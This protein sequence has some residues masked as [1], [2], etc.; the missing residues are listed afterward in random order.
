MFFKKKENK[1]QRT[2]KEA[3]AAPTVQPQTDS[4]PNRSTQSHPKKG[5]PLFGKVCCTLISLS[6]IA[7]SCYSIVTLIRNSQKGGESKDSYITL[8]NRNVNQTREA[9][10][11]FKQD[12]QK[13]LK[14]YYFIGTK[15]YVSENKITPS[16]YEDNLFSRAGGK[17]IALLD[18]TNKVSYNTSNATLIKQNRPYIDLDNTP[19]GDYLLYPYSGEDHLRKSDIAP[20]SLDLAKGVEESV[21]SLP[22]GDKKTRKTITLKNN[23]NSPYTIISV[24]ESGSHLPA[25]TYDYVIRNQQYIKG[26]DG[27]YSLNTNRNSSPASKDQ[28]N[29][30]AEKRKDEKGYKCKVAS[31]L[32]EAVKTKAKKLIVFTSS[33]TY[34]SIFLS[35]KSENTL[36]L[37]DTDLKGYDEIPEIREAT[38][39]IEHAGENYYK[40]P[41][42]S[43][44]PLS[45]YK[46]RDVTR[47]PSSSITD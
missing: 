32:S 18:I 46:G 14:D 22:S 41:F 31:S 24:E 10:N 44:S 19:E 26:E 3:K 20:Y 23:L 36:V 6:R 30:Y 4:A 13:K 29:S 2:E 37:T 16:R 33:S 17:D 34:Q 21:Y 15:L 47:I 25:D 43:F 38:G 45:D 12:N 42:N 1:E 27:S 40:V 39:K 7:L 35:G 8:K 5:F 9:L 28:L 11:G